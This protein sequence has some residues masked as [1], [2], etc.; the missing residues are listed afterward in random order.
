MKPAKLPG[1]LLLLLSPLL[2]CSCVSMPNSAAWGRALLKT[3]GTVI[4]ESVDGQQWKQADAVS[5][6]QLRPGPHRVMI[7]A[8][9]RTPVPWESGHI[10]DF[11]SKELVFDAVRG[12]TY[13]IKFRQLALTHIIQE[14]GNHPIESFLWIEEER[15]RDVV[16]GNSPRL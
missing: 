5:H 10:W 6:A 8:V 2:S 14:N 7:S 15:S 12:N 4:I 11:L 3:E 16:A 1:W 9:L 13:C